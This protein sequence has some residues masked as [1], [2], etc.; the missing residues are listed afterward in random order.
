MVPGSLFWLS[1][2][3]SA[4][5]T[6]RQLLTHCALQARGKD[7]PKPVKTWNQC[8]LS[9]RALEVLRKAEFELPLAI[10]VRFR[11][12]LSICLL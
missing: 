5:S 8:G 6:K 4:R 7:V 3:L 9:S 1:M 12:C 11:C 10:Q 2:M